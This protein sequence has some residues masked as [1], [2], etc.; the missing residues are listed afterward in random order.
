MAAPVR[1]VIA[2]H[3]LGKIEE[4]ADL[5]KGYDIEPVAGP[6]LGLAVPD[7]TETSFAGNAA[8]KAIAAARATGLAA[9]ADDSGLCVDALGGAPGVYTADWAETPGGRDFGLAMERVH[10]E[11][12]ASGAA[13]PW[14]AEFRCA[15]ALALPD[16]TCET[17]EGA[18]RGA[19][20]WPPRGTLGHGY[21]P[22]FVPAGEALSFGEIDRWVKN[23]RSHRAAALK[24]LEP[25]LQHLVSRETPRAGG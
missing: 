23:R 3:N 21:D 17:A 20:V 11:I 22:I 8:L 10:D 9:L 4:F 7:E 14:G 2:T 19:I 24:A 18:V 5:L 15:L 25:A 6:D 16:G 12:A 1:L 13:A